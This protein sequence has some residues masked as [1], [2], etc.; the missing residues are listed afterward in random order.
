MGHHFLGVS[1]SSSCEKRCLE[2][3]LK[4][5]SKERY[6]YSHPRKDRKVTD[7]HVSGILPFDL[8]FRVA[9]L[10]YWVAH[11]EFLKMMCVIPKYAHWPM[12]IGSL[13]CFHY[14]NFLQTPMT[15]NDQQSMTQW[16][17]LYSILISHGFTIN[18]YEWATISL[19]NMFRSIGDILRLNSYKH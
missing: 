10:R 11:M 12:E 4:T 14:P 2:H 7:Q 9:I 15:S 16:C 8:F 3:P 17:D 13:L 19:F 18:G 6:Q 1:G 5:C